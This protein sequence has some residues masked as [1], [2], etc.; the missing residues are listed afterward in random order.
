M[1]PAQPPLEIILEFTSTRDSTAS[2]EFSWTEEKYDV[3]A[4]AGEGVV[5]PFPWHEPWF[6]K[7]LERLEEPE[8]G[9]E[10]LERLG[11]CLRDFLR[12]TYWMREEDKIERALNAQPSR[13]V[14]LT[15]RSNADELYYLP[16]ELLALRSGRRL[17]GLKEYLIQ[18]ERLPV[19]SQERIIPPKG[20]ILLAC[21][22]AGGKIPAAA[23]EEAI[24]SACERVG[25][26]FDSRLDVLHGLSRKSL[27]DALS[28]TAR[29]VTALHLL[30]HGSLVGTATYGLTFN[31]VKSAHHSERLDATQLRDLI[32]S[33]PGSRS[34]RLV[35]LCSCQG[36]DAGT[37][38]NLLGSV[39]RMFHQQGVPAVIASRMPLSSTGSVRLTEELYGGLLAERNLREV[40]CA[41]RSRLRNELRSRDWLSLQLYARAGD[42]SALTPF[43]A[44]SR[45]PEESASAEAPR[46]AAEDRPSAQHARG[47][48]NKQGMHIHVENMSVRDFIV[49][50][51]DVNVGLKPGGQE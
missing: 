14:H 4:A 47:A 49:A 2:S 13:P 34:L 10:V 5:V 19:Q 32:F 24:R 40:L 3:K 16:W 50:G 21:S 31:S 44:Y 39:A 37:P 7:A 51:R 28:D 26:P 36:G 6:R 12:P 48:R 38:A 41:V 17:V 42:A 15:I 27:I 1:N 9:S 46:G 23:H 30:C 11:R 20:R 22:E 25:F 18:Y 33:S 45:G 43:G 8:P 29:P 35:T